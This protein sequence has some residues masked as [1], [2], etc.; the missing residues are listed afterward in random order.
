MTCQAARVKMQKYEEKCLSTRSNVGLE[1]RFFGCLLCDSPLFFDDILKKY[2]N[3]ER[4]VIKY[5]E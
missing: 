1:R 2:I 5:D 4:R 3:N